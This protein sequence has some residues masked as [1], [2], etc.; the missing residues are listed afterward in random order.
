MTFKVAV[1]AAP[2]AGDLPVMEQCLDT[3]NAQRP[4][5]EVWHMGTGKASLRL[6]AWAKA[7]NVQ[8]NV[9][10]TAVPDTWSQD[11]TVRMVVSDAH[12]DYVL[13]LP[14]GGIAAAIAD[15]LVAAGAPVWRVG[16]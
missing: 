9:F 11:Q 8:A 12:P 3:I 10:K 14:C 2:F 13:R 4:I 15:Y 16:D 5:T 7:H 6:L 1:L